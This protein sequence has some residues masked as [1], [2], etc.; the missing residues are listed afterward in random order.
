MGK[1]E[2]FY[3]VLIGVLVVILFISF[4]ACWKLY[5]GWTLDANRAD[6]ATAKAKE[7]SEKEQMRTRESLDM[8]EI[9][10]FAGDIEV[11][12]IKEEHLKNMEKYGR[13]YNGN[14][15]TYRAVCEA[16]YNAIDDRDQKLLAAQRKIEEL[17]SNLA[18][19]E[20]LFTSIAQQHDE[21]KQKAVADYNAE[22]QNLNQSL[23]ARSQ[24]LEQLKNEKEEAATEAEARIEKVENEKGELEERVNIL[25]KRNTDTVKKLMEITRIDFDNPAGKITGVNQ[26]SG[27]VF[28]NIGSADGLAVRTVFTVYDPKITGISFPT[29]SDDDGGAANREISKNASKAS[30]EI[31]KILGQHV[32]EGRILSDELSNPVL[33]GDVIYTPLWKPGQR[34]RF[35]LTNGMIIEGLGSRDDA[36]AGD[37]GLTTVINLIRMNGG[38]VDAYIDENGKVVGEMTPE[39]TFLV[40]GDVSR[41]DVRGEAM[42]RRAELKKT[43][44]ELGIRVIP[45]HELLR[46]MGWKNVTPVTGYG[47]FATDDDVKMPT[48][49]KPVSSGTVSPLYDKPNRAARVNNE[50]RPRPVSNGRVSPLFDAGKTSASGGSSSAGS[51]SDLFRPRKPPVTGEEA[52]RQ[53]SGGGQE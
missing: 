45:L 19:T 53:Q 1:Q 15:K 44:S 47:R 5:D 37:S 4:F 51:V 8:K 7:A 17:E 20:A 48:E 14:E 3:Q 34:Q 42:Q 21:E 40:D 31:T 32:A 29:D 36:S 26:A 2:R 50:E 13:F 35:A 52:E 27:V 39:T 12:A 38:H 22:T 28:V 24:E 18:N 33:T 11:R 16:F 46:M 43:A 9:T 25:A 10:G 41:E 6:D 30:I 23:S 49:Y